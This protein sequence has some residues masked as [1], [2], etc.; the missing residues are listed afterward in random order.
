LQCNIE[1]DIP[2]K[3]VKYFDIFDDGDPT[4]P[5]RFSCEVCGGEMRPVSYNGVHGQKYDLNDTTD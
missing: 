3:V 4:V 5:P 2:K 1:E